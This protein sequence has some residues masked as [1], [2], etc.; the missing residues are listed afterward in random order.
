MHY[1]ACIKCS[2]KK[3]HLVYF[4]KLKFQ[5]HNDEDLVEYSQ[6]VST[7]QTEM[8]QGFSSVDDK[9]I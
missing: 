4:L 7:D 1:E 5:D 6:Q 2:S 8:I 9:L 3:S